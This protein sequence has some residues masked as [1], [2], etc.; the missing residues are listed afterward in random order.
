MYHTAARVGLVKKRVRQRQRRQEKRALYSLSA[1]C[2]LLFISLVGTIGAFTGSKHSAALSVYGSILLHEEVGGYV[3]VGV[4]SFTAAV[5]ITVLCSKYRKR[6]K[7]NDP[8]ED[9][10]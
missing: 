6:D 2:L 5:I 4:I 1:L 3:L 8:K 10:L 7:T 9:A